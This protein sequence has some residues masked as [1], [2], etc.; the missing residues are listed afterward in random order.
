MGKDTI[1][2]SMNRISFIY[3]GL[4]HLIGDWDFSEVPDLILASY[5]TKAIAVKIPGCI[6][7]VD[8]YRKVESP[9][10]VTNESI[11]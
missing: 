1:R 3:P 9:L 6:E 4:K 8:G 7:S 10:K 5:T 11:D 2:D